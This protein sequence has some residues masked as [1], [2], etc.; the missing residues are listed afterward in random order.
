MGRTTFPYKRKKSDT[1]VFYYLLNYRVE[2]GDEI[3][4][5]FLSNMGNAKYLFIE[6]NMI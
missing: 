4:K 3:T 2:S 6:L 5:D 1:G